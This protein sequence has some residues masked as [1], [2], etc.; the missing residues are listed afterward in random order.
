VT[1]QFRAE[2]FNVFNRVNFISD[3]GNVN[4][5]WTPNNVVFNT[6]NAA[7]ATSIVSATPQGGFGQLNRAADP[8]QMQFGVRLS[9]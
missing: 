1:L 7:T 9:F 5:T 6:G 2:M 3:D 4:V 8:R